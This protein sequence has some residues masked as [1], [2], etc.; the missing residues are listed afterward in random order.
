MSLERLID[1]LAESDVSFVVV[2]MIAGQLYGSRV[3]TYDLD[4]V[5]ERTEENLSRLSTYLLSIDA[6][7]KETWPNEGFASEFVPSL[8]ATELSLTLGT[9]Q[10][11]IDLL[12]R[13][14][15]IGDYANA[16]AKSQPFALASGREIR[17]LTLPALIDAKRASNRDKDR[18]HLT[19]LEAIA[20]IRTSDDPIS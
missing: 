5:Y 16:L 8:L 20:E 18:L 4:I 6:Y 10:G 7:V 3:A 12:H 13:I 1:G 19:E 9:V 14:D 2:G 15:G 17:V 11:E